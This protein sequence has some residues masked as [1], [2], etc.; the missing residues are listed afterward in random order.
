MDQYEHRSWPAW[1]RH[2]LM[3]F[4]A[5][6]FLLRMKLKFKK[7]A[8]A[9]TLPQCRRLIETILPVIP[10]DTHYTLRV[11]EYYQNRNYQAY[12][13]HRKKKLARLTHWQGLQIRPVA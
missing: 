10:F 11:I 7:K 13:S 6:F 5:Q 9:L 2:M 12:L 3:V 1:H 4:L 8:P